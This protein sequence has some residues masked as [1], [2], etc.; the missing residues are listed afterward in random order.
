VDESRTKDPERQRLGRLG[1]LVTHARGRTNVGPARIAWERRLADEFGISEDLEP[2]ERRRRMDFAMRVR[3][4][5]MA[6]SRWGNR[7]T[8]A[9]DQ[10]PAPARGG[11]RV[12]DDPRS[13]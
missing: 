12:T 2:T 7:K 1:A 13:A 10:H 9:E 5:E 6:R 11:R 8:G 4:T 3:M